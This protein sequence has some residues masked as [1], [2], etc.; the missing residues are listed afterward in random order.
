MLDYAICGPTPLTRE[1]FREILRDGGSPAAQESDGMYLLLRNAD[2]RLEV[3]LAFF[4]QESRFGTVGICR[5]FDLRNPGMV[6]SPERATTART[7]VQT[8][9]GPFAKYPT[10]ADGAAD[11]ATRMTGPKYAGA[12]LTTVRTVLPKYAPSGDQDNA[13]TAYINA[14]LASIEEWLGKGAPPVAVLQPPPMD[15]SHQSPNRNGYGGKRRVDAIVWHVTA[16]SFGSSLGWLTN[17][18][19]SASANYLLDK[20]GSIYELVPPDQDAWANGAVNKPDT[21]NPLI[22][23]WQAEG[24]NFNQRTVSIETAQ[25]HS[26]NEQPGGF[27]EAQ[28]R[29]LVRLT[30]WLCQTYHLTPDRTHVF[31]HRSID[32]VNRQHCPGLSEEEWDAWVGE[33]AELVGGTTP[34]APPVAD[35]GFPGALT[36]TGGLVIN[37]QSP[38]DP[39]TLIVVEAVEATG[40][41]QAGE[42]YSIKWESHQW[43]PW[44]RVG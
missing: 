18:A 23:K 7:T 27:T 15:K 31:G 11:W 5:E 1:R 9:R 6:R 8:P 2:V 22:R 29:S 43:G 30:A 19:S 3:F 14:V 28:H 4:R 24:V 40:R 26:A 41:N 44:R 25:E 35:P 36:P 37:G 12:G 33:I 10:W 17:P 42:H 32:S 13:P 38:P 16:G 21:S 34:P 39:G 20:D